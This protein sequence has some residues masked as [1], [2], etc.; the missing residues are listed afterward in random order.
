MLTQTKTIGKDTVEI[1]SGPRGTVSC[2]INVDNRNG[3]YLF[4]DNILA[5]TVEEAYQMTLDFGD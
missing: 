5:D 1:V 2:R 4:L 3:T